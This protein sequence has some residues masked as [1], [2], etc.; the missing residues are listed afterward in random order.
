MTL[1]R[2]QKVLVTGGG[3]GIGRAIAA[4]FAVDG[5]D[6]MICGRR[7]DVLK[8]TAQSENVTWCAGDIAQRGEAHRIVDEARKHL[9]GLTILVN[10]A[11]A[12]AMRPLADTSDDL[13]EEIVGVNLIGT[14]C[15]TR[16]ALRVL[17]RGG[18][19]LNISST[20][21]HAV[22][23]QMVPYAATKAALDHWTRC[24]AV[25]VADR[26][27]RVNAVAPGATKTPGLDAMGPDVEAQMIA[28]T[29]MGRIGT[30]SDIAN[31]VRLLASPDA[32]W[33]TGQTVDASGGLM[34]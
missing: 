23:P 6:V 3:T 26:G 19:I 5:A 14:L 12:Y 8:R 4:A 1:F 10:N 30:P 32:S 33:V 13:L 7:A 9:G 29:P 20:A 2:G 25:E 28:M 34:L 24:L 21:G 16:E 31:V 17:P 27:I 15:M 22:M 18:Q 11:A